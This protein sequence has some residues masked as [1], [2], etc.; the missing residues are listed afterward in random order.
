MILIDL[1]KLL[2]RLNQMTYFQ[3]WMMNH[4]N[5]FINSLKF[6]KLFILKKND[7]I[8]WISSK[9]PEKWKFHSISSTCLIN[10]L[11]LLNWLM[12]AQFNDFRN[13]FNGIMLSESWNMILL[14]KSS[15][16]QQLLNYLVF[17]II[18]DCFHS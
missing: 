13:Y 4:I 16:E 3:C 1:A 18:Y 9:T 14:W 5:S 2:D 11:L 17:N 7:E 8:R 6:F 12:R 15:N 10:T